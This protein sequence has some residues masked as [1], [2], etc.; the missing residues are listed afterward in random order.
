MAKKNT[1]TTNTT[2]QEASPMAPQETPAKDL[3][4]QS[5]A[6]L[7]AA[8]NLSEALAPYDVMIDPAEVGRIINENAGNAGIDAFMLEMIKVPSGGGTYFMIPDLAGKEVPTETVEGI[9]IFFNDVRSYWE[10]SIEDGGG[11]V[12]PQCSSVDLQTGQGNPGGDCAKCPLNGFGSDLKGGRGKA[13]TERRLLFLLRPGEALP[14]V[15]SVPPTSLAPVRQF[16]LRLGSKRVSYYALVMQISL[17]KEKNAGGVEYAEMV[18]KVK[19]QL[20]G[21]DLK[22]VEQ[23]R[24]NLIPALSRVRAE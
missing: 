12:P 1:A 19:A 5:A 2:P 11:K 3:V 17:K 21:D 4:V 24:Q 15:V 6:A 9:V 10:K 7:P 20:K 16:F 14:A 23:F 13:C 18:F 22:A 8:L